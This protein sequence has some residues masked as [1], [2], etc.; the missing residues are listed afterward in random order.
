[1]AAG[2]PV[3][4]LVLQARIK[5]KDEGSKTGSSQMRQLPLISL[6]RKLANYFHVY[7]IGQSLITWI[8][9]NA[10]NW[11]TETFRWQC[12]QLKGRTYC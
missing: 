2:A 6:P 9:L 4:T 12:I 1:M 11:E 3:I 5:R 7:F 10:G 8:D